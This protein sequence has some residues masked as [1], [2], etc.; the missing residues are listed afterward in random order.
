MNK[1]ANRTAAATCFRYYASTVDFGAVP[2]NQA[3]AQRMCRTSS[4]ATFAEKSARQRQPGHVVE[5][6]QHHRHRLDDPAQPIP[7]IDN[8]AVSPGPR[9][10]PKWSGHGRHGRR[11]HFRR[12]GRT[13][14]HRSSAGLLER[15]QRWP[16]GAASDGVQKQPEGVVAS[17]L[18]GDGR[19]D[20][21]SA[22][23]GADSISLLYTK[24]GGGFLPMGFVKTSSPAAAH[25]N[26]SASP[27]AT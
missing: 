25:R 1:M 27:S 12:S 16:D 11:Q 6:A 8:N 17:D 9:N 21:V 15:R 19:P 23:F 10:R 24:P 3:A 13:V 26:R 14:G 7:M 2:F 4:S 22:N 20:I 5:V 18:N